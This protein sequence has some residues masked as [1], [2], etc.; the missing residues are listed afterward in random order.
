[1]NYELL[2]P[3]MTFKKVGNKDRI[4]FSSLSIFAKYM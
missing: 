2:Y 3:K 4:G 1:M